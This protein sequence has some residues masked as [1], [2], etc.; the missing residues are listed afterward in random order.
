[1]TN[2]RKVA[3]HAG[4]SI[5][6]VSRVFNFPDKVLPE[7]RRRI[8]HSMDIVGYRPFRG[9]SRSKLLG[10]IV[11]F[12]TNPYYADLVDVI[13]EEAARHGRKVLIFCAR[14]ETRREFKALAECKRA[15][16]DGVFLV[17]Q[18]TRPE[19]MQRCKR[20]RLPIVLMTRVS[21]KF[22]CVCVDHIE[23]GGLAAKHLLSLGHQNI[24]YVGP[25][26]DDE[27]KFR[28][29]NNYLNA[30]GCYMPP[31]FLFETEGAG[32][33]DDFIKSLRVGRSKKLKLSAIFCI[34]DVYAYHVIASLA[35]Y[36]IQVPDDITVVG[37]DNSMLSMK[38]GITS[39]SQ[40]LREIA[41]V[42]FDELTKRIEFKMIPQN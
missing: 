15:G 21:S 17:P 37:F 13:E 28:G 25:V 29:F 32:V 2:I 11:P 18:N 8:R 41:H 33:L 20:Y 27:E 9:G 3:R 36:G 14:N 38:L 31:E 10:L 4:V 16:V 42:A 26:T 5:A 23:G 30:R 19:H 12:V 39:I 35:R 22:P 1:M 7:T 24:G 6:T 34:N 40:P